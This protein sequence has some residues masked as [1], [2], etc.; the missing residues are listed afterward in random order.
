VENSFDANWEC[1]VDGQLANRIT[2]NP[3]SSHRQKLCEWRSNEFGKHLLYINATSR[4]NG[5]F[6]VDYI[7]YLP[8]PSE[9]PLTGIIQIPHDDPDFDFQGQRWREADGLGRR[10][11]LTDNSAKINFVGALLFLYPSSHSSDQ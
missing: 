4:D 8:S 3:G 7:S 9:G 11:R 5:R 2:N 1:L 6:L 10:T